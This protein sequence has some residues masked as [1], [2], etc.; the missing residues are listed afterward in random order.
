MLI[1]LYTSNFIGNYMLFQLWKIFCSRV[2]QKH[3]YIRCLILINFQKYISKISVITKQ[4][5]PKYEIVGYVEVSICKNN[6]IMIIID[7]INIFSIWSTSFCKREWFALSSASA[8]SKSKSVHNFMRKVRISIISCMKN[9]IFFVN[10]E[11]SL[12]INLWKF[13]NVAVHFKTYDNDQKQV[14]LT[15]RWN[16]QKLSKDT[17]PF[18][19]VSQCFDLSTQSLLNYFRRWSFM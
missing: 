14:I 5:V 18:K 19:Y 6:N 4:A 16:D 17:R 7:N 2:I 1:K 3:H 10:C 15:K 11:T 12:G 13:K 8:L 9:N